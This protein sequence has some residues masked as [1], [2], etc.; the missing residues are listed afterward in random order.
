MGVRARVRVRVK[1]CMEGREVLSFIRLSQTVR[2]ERGERGGLDCETWN[3]R[4]EGGTEG[5]RW[6]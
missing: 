1:V 2:A 5:G 3:G 6:T 4:R